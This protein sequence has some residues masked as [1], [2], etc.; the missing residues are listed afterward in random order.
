MHYIDEA[1]NITIIVIVIT[2][3]HFME[4]VTVVGPSFVRAA[5]PQEKGGVVKSTPI[6]GR[7]ELAGE[8]QSLISSY[9]RSISASK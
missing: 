7:F 8:F 9:S 4:V 2:V 3:S 6:P 1:C 5:H